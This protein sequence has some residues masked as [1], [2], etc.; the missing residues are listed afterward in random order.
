MEKTI[1]RNLITIG[2]TI[3]IINFVL[4]LTRVITGFNTVPFI[5]FLMFTFAITHG[6]LRYGIK[7]I[8]YLMLLTFVVSWA[9]E[10][11]SIYTGFPFGNYHYTDY[12]GPKI[13]VVPWTIM[14]TYFSMGY[15]SWGIASILIDKRDS[16]IT[17]SDVLLH[18]VLA[19]FIMV[20]WDVCFDPDSSTISGYWI[21]HDGGEYFGV[22]FSNYLGWYLCVFTF[23]F[24]FSL[25]RRYSKDNDSK[26]VVIKNKAFWILLVLMY[27]QYSLGFFYNGIFGDNVEVTAQNGY[28]YWTGDIYGSLM[29]VTIFTMVFV[30]FYAVVRIIRHKD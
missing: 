24:I 25:M 30:S 18:P 27:L 7:N 15:F 9:Y 17:G 12:L 10:T 29:L 8:I 13:G 3:V 16:S 21:W 14:P 5:T 23:Y 20:M 4:V 2:I 22:P 19:S 11:I 6:A 1:N 28:T 26:P